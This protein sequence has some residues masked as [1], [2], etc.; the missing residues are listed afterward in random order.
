MLNEKHI[1]SKIAL[2][3]SALIWGSTFVVVKNVTESMST[4]FILALRFSIGS[5]VLMMIFYKKLK[6]INKSYLRDGFIMGIT[7]FLSYWMQVFGLTL[8]TTP[9]KSAFLCATYCV[10]VPFL[11]WGLMR[12]RPNK[13]NF[14]AAFICI[15]GIGLVSL[16]ENLYIT[17]GDLLT[18]LSGFFA[19]ANIIAT[20][21]YCKEKDALMLTILQLA[22]VSILSWFIVMISGGLPREYTK[23]GIFSIVY[24]GIFA[25]AIGL[26][27]QSIGIK[28]TNPSSAALILS[29]ES[30][31]GVIFSIILYD[32]EITIKPIFG[33]LFIFI[34]V[35]ISETKLEILKKKEDVI[36][37]NESS[38]K[39]GFK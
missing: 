30:V 20:S 31:F 24:L 35:V 5:L 11:Y 7:L 12:E 37:E 21:I 28:Y 17:L 27:F 19:A 23:E 10:I 8:D 9:G 1:L 25:T 36:I 4:S 14:I 6:L 29:L 39:E 15:I 3:T 16:N 22:V 13:Y 26:L 33:F 18:I 38:S 2:F 34:A 32:E